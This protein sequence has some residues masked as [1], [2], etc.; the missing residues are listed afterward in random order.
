MTITRRALGPND[1]LVDVLYASICHTDIHTARNEWP[2]LFPANYPCVP[3]HEIVGRVIAVGNKV[4][5]FKIGDVAGVG[6]MVDADLTCDNCLDDREQNCLSGTT[7]TYNSPDPISGG[8]T[9]GGYSDRIVV[10]EHFGIRIPPGA[11]LA[12]TAPLLCA[13]VTTFSPMQYWKL[14]AGQRVGIIGLGGLGHIA[15]KL[16]P[17]P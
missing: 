6:C 3:G 12:A 5:K 1:I 11:D 2:V 13:G 4:T 7:Y 9:F 14:A 10:K 16:C 17:L 15:V 8:Y